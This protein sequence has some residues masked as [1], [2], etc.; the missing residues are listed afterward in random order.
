MS[1]GKKDYTP[2]VSF[3]HGFEPWKLFLDYLVLINI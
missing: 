1:H 2:L 3:G